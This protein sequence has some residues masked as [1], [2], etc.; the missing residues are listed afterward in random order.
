MADRLFKVSDLTGE[1]IANEADLARLVVEGYGELQGV[2]ITLDVLPS[3]VEG[4]I[5]E[6][7]DLVVLSYY[8]PGAT[9][10]R[11]F[12]MERTDFE[13]LS[14]TGDMTQ[15]LASARR[16]QAL[17]AAPLRRGRKRAQAGQTEKIDYASPEHAGEPHRGRATEAEKEYVRAHLSEVN[18]RLA[19]DGR[20]S[21]DPTDAKMAKR[22]GL[23]PEAAAA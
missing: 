17:E 4:E 2:P 21:I 5:P 3:E 16:A 19:R 13:K 6:D 15:V 18:A 8:P 14:H 23:E 22:Y 7:G 9:A 10:G 1:I 20:R 12:F 11:R